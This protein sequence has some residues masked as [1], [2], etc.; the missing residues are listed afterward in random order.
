MQKNDYCAK[1]DYEHLCVSVIFA[2]III[3]HVFNLIMS[4]SQVS[5]DFM[6][7]LTLILCMNNFMTNAINKYESYFLFK[8]SFVLSSLSLRNWTFSSFSCH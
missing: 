6:Q 5:K 3:H 2:N 8:S 4:E 1:I 7:L